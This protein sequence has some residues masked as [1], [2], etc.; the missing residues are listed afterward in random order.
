MGDLIAFTWAR[1]GSNHS[2]GLRDTRPDVFG[3]TR[4][5]APLARGTGFGVRTIVKGGDHAGT[6]GYLSSRHAL[7]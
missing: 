3:L 5:T 7:F 1:T 2:S 4:T 6:G